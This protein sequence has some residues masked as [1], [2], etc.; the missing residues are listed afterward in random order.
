MRSKAS[1]IDSK[2]ARHTFAATR[3]PRNANP[4]HFI[5]TSIMLIRLLALVFAISFMGNAS[6][7][8]CLGSSHLQAKFN[9]AEYVFVAQVLSKADVASREEPLGSPGVLVRLRLGEVFKATLPAP[10]HVTTGMGSGDCGVPIFLGLSYVFFVDK[11]GQID[12]CSGTRLYVRGITYA[13]RYLV[14][15]RFL[16]HSHNSLPADRTAPPLPSEVFVDFDALDD[17]ILGLDFHD[18]FL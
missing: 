1:P 9:S 14:D 18:S 17:Q 4:K 16:A 13:E 2:T 10:A 5:D 6:A 8:S 3:L 7:C 15:V 11:L 12:I